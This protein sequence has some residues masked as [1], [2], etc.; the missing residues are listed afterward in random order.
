MILDL[1][2]S[3]AGRQEC[4]PDAEASRPD[5][6]RRSEQ[7]LPA[8]DPELTAMVVRAREGE[9]LAQAELVRRYRIRLSGFVR[10]MLRRPGEVEDLVQVVWIK[11]IRRL[12]SLR[13]PQRF[14]TWLFTL[15]RN[16]VLDH[17]RRSR[18]RPETLVDDR[19]L[20]ALPDPRRRELYDEIMEA[21]RVAI[22]ECGVRERRVL[23]ELIAGA[24]YQAIATREG[25]SLPA[26]KVRIHRLRV[27][28]RV[29]V[30]EATGEIPAPE[31][32]KPADGTPPRGGRKGRAFPVATR[33]CDQR[34]SRH[35][36]SPSSFS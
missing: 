21:L 19:L 30:R 3:G 1:K 8:V 34:G 26:M 33:G 35:D 2:E 5:S 6:R 22:Q 15:A 31:K 20:H 9:S 27:F 13:E 16:T 17:L 24:S 11:M 10:P 18:C 23:Q 14:E 28:L 7:P 4:L 29:R 36:L 25:V 32:V 12:R